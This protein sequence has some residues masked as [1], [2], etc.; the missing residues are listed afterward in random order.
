[1]GTI[2]KEKT[3]TFDIMDEDPLENVFDIH[4]NSF[5]A[6]RSVSWNRQDP[7]LELR[8]WYIDAEGN[9]T[10]AKGINFHTEQGPHQLT[11]LLLK[12][13]YGDNDTIDAIMEERRKLEEEGKSITKELNKKKKSSI[14]TATIKENM[15]ETKKANPYSA[16][17]LIKNISISTDDDE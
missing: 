1:M 6:I 2:Y 11:H 3:I 14:A 8:R 7:K 10:P 5:L 4:N 17:N 15:V 9:E 16:N 12:L 13:G